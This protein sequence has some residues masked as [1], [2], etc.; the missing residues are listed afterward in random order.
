MHRTSTLAL[1]LALSAALCGCALTGKAVSPPAICPEPPKPPPE[2]MKTPDFE[3][4][5]RLI[6]FEQE[7][8]AMP[9]SA[10]GIPMPEP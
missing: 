1:S 4:R 2:L 10:D 7:P 3:L 5:A 8:N 6:L 9:G